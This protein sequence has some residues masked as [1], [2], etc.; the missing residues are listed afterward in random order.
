M[1][2]MIEALAANVIGLSKKP[3][4]WPKEP[5]RAQQRKLVAL[6]NETG[7]LAS[8]VTAGIDIDPVVAKVRF[9]NRRVAVD[10]ELAEILLVKQEVL[11][12]PKHVLLA[13]ALQGHTRLHAGIYEKKSPQQNEVLS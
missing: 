4:D 11:A 1:S 12:N 7:Q 9:A 6:D 10:D 2:S 8:R 3:M 13:L 5:L